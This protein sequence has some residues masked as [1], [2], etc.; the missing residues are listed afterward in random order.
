MSLGATHLT[1]GGFGGGGGGGWLVQDTVTVPVP[2]PSAA[3][4]Q[5]A[6]ATPGTV[7]A[8]VTA[9]ITVR[10]MCMAVPDQLLV[11]WTVRVAP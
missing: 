9:M 7:R 5:Y 4:V 3:L 8:N 10:L 11:T 1:S 6:S 2:E